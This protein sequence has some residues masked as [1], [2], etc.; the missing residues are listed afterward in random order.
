MTLEP[1][2]PRK[3]DDFALKLLDLS[4]ALRRMACRSREHG[5]DELALHDKKAREWSGQLARWV[6]RAEADLEMRI[7]EVRAER[8]AQ[9]LAVWD[10]VSPEGP[11]VA[12]RQQS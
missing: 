6:R 10:Q 12:H 4:A 11:V 5:L 7:A 8:Q 2:D 1:Y 9:S 3:L